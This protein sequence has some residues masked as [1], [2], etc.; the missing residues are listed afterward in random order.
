MKQS[1]LSLMPKNF[2]LKK[3][4]EI[5]DKIQK[6]IEEKEKATQQLIG[7]INGLKKTLAEFIV[8]KEE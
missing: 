6:E 7:Y 3:F 8:L 5:V 2:D 1:N 4:Q